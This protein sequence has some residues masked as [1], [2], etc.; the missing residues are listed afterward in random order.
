LLDNG[1]E[2]LS[3]VLHSL[4]PKKKRRKGKNKREIGMKEQ[5][6]RTIMSTANL[7]FDV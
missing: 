2:F 6:K 4:S 3:F 1:A 7:S 5:M